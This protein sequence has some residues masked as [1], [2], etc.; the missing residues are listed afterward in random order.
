MFFFSPFNEA[1]LFAALESTLF[2]CC[3]L[4]NG[5]FNV[6]EILHK[7]HFTV[8]KKDSGILK[9]V[10][11]DFESASTFKGRKITMIQNFTRSAH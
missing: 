8:K 3:D 1:G 4:F 10:L 7:I 6:T 9:K 5:D 11:V 2:M